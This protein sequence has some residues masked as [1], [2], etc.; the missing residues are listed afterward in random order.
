MIL[1]RRTWLATALALSAGAA[2]QTGPAAEATPA[3]TPE[4]GPE[5]EIVV[6]GYGDIVVNGRAIR[7]HAA[8][9][10]PLDEVSVGSNSGEHTMIVP[11]GQGGFSAT[12]VTE[13][14][15]GPEFWQRVG[16]GIGAYRFR[17]PAGGNPMC[18]G[19]RGGANSHNTFGGFRRI[20]DAA[21]FRGHRVRFTAWVATRK[22]GQVSFWLATGSQLEGG[23]LLDGG[24]TNNVPLG[25]NNAWT[26]VLLETGPIHE[27][28]RHVSYGFNLQGRGDVWVY[29]PKLE[30]VADH[31]PGSDTGDL[32][33]IGRSP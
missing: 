7:C 31:P 25:G 19:A 3:S 18:I 13:R 15:T 2:A 12:R 28:A 30:I 9:G 16:V 24:N 20:L 11:D 4:E 33:L 29:E 26:P 8:A 17:A 10:D 22:A 6:T 5:L 23:P 1:A 21:R 27:D 32:I 14:M